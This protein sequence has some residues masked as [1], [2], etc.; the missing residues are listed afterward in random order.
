MLEREVSGIPPA[1]GFPGQERDSFAGLKDKNREVF[2][3]GF[4]G[5]QVDD[6]IVQVAERAITFDALVAWFRARLVKTT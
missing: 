4:Q 1:V 6:V 2:W 3:Q 5:E